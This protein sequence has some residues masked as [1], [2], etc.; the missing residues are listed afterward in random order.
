MRRPLLRAVPYAL[1]GWPV[2]VVNPVL[3]LFAA[4]PNQAAPVRITPAVVAVL[5][6]ALSFRSVLRTSVE[7]RARELAVTNS[8]ARYVLSPDRIQRI[9]HRSRFP[10]PTGLGIDLTDGRS[11]ELGLSTGLSPRRHAELCD[12]LHDWARANRVYTRFQVL[13]PKKLWS[14]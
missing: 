7:F 4:I 6:L 10:Y 8:F 3:W 12:L 1:V 2:P 13:G 11:I 14:D 5:L 9:G